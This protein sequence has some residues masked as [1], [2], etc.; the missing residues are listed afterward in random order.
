MLPRIF[1]LRPGLN[2]AEQEARRRV[3]IILQGSA[4]PRKHARHAS[5]VS[6]AAETGCGYFITE[7]AR[8]L[9]KRY[10]LS[11]CF[12]HLSKL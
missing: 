6:E 1:N 8:I 3:A 12:P 10:E 5:H 4:R 7:D 11:V 2:T 9:R